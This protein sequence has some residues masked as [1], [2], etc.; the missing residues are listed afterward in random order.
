MPTLGADR[1]TRIGRALLRAAGASPEEAEAVAI[2]C[3]N[4]NLVGH[5]SHGI[6]AIPTYIDRI[7][8]GHIVP[9]APMTDRAGIAYNDGDRRALGFWLPRQ[10]QGDGADHREGAQDQRR[11][12]HGVSPEPRRPARRLSADGDRARHDRARHRRLRPVGE[13][14]RAVRR[15][16]GA[17]RHQSDLD[18]GAV[19]SRRPV[20]SRHG[21]VGGGGGKSDAR[22]R[23]RRGRFRPAGSSTP[24]ASSPPT[25]PS[26]ARAARCSP[27]AAPRATRAAALRRWS[28]SCA[29]SSPA[30]A[31]ASSRPDGTTTG[32]SWRCS[33][34]RHSGRSP[35]SRRRSP[36]SPAI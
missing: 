30:S 35:S 25:R 21:D 27:S 29:G 1:L 23:A 13:G 3:V 15:P 32:A 28:K 14:R 34:S 8:V 11:R 5:D 24:T 20:L 31:S 9:G 16:R 7:K 17:A 2:G 22:R 26:C 12:L 19:R 36:S 6:I 10:C 33:T 4:A 18:R